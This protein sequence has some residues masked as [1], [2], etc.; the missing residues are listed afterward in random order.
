MREK[1]KK[2]RERE[3]RKS[4]EKGRNTGKE[5]YTH[6]ERERT[7]KSRDRKRDKYTLEKRNTGKIEIDKYTHTYI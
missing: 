4:G 3:I 6:R 2:S 7:Q 1:N 5:K